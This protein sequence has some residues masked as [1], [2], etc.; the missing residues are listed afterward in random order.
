MFHPSH[1][2]PPNEPFLFLSQPP[3]H[4][5]THKHLSLSDLPLN[6]VINTIIAIYRH[7]KV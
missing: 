4:P 5:P 2:H 7:H 1:P 3:H 6:G